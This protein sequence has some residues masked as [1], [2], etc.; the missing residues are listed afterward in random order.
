MPSC[1][2]IH[3]MRFTSSAKSTERKLNCWQREAMVVGILCDFGGAQ[4]EHDPLGR[5]L[6]RLQ[7]RVEGFAGDLVRFVDDEDLV[8]V[9]RR[10]VADVLAQLAHFVDAAIGGRVDLDHVHASCRRRFRGNWRTR[11]RASRV[12]PLIAV[13]AARQNAR[14]GGFA[15]AALARKN[16]AV[17]D[18]LLRDGVFERGLDVFLADQLRKRLRPVFPGDDLIHGRI[19]RRYARP[20]VIRGTRVKPLPLLPSGPGGVCSRPLHEAR[21][22]TTSNAS[23]RGREAAQKGLYSKQGEGLC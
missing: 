19:E 17:R 18:A 9:A 14:D 23:M 2:Q 8:A 15:G 3:S 13:Q 1:S 21:S 5:L 11:R 16:V 6:Q 7:Q 10:P 12:G 20:R 22:L 4:D